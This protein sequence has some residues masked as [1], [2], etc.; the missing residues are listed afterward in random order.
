MHLLLT[1]ALDEAAPLF[2]DRGW[3]RPTPATLADAE[4]LLRLTQSYRAPTV[5]VDADGSLRLEW[6][7][8]EAGW[9]AFTV[10]GRSQVTH[11]AVIGDDEFEKTEALGDTLPEWAARLLARLMQVG[12]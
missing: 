3:T 11:S 12:H 5:Q 6:E 9:L 1:A 7:A 8:G 2:A 4:R 10:D